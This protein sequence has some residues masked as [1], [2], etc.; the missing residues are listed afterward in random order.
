[1]NDCFGESEA[2]LGTKSPGREPSFKQK[3]KITGQKLNLI[4]GFFSP[5]IPSPHVAP[6]CDSTFAQTAYRTKAY[7]VKHFCPIG[8]RYRTNLMDK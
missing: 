7:H 3:T 6:P 2:G 4:A 8:T 5:Q 1:M